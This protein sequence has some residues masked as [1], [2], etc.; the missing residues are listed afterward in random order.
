[1]L[2]A[3]FSIL[4]AG[5]S[6]APLIISFDFFMTNQ[7]THKLKATIIKRDKELEILLLESN[8]YNFMHMYYNLPFNYI[9]MMPQK[10]RPDDSGRLDLKSIFWDL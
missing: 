10:K 1:M 7:A 3:L 9:T 2:D 8:R 5:K 4:N 6:G